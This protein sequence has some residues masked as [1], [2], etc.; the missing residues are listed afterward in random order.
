MPIDNN[1]NGSSTMARKKAFE[2]ESKFWGTEYFPEGLS[3]C[4]F[5]TY[6]Q[7][8]LLEENG[9]TY[10][11]LAE[12]IEAPAFK[13]EESFVDVFTGSKAAETIHEKT[14]KRFLEVSNQKQGVHFSVGA[15]SSSSK[16]VISAQD[17]DV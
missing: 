5:F 9:M 10:K 3:R 1:Q 4:G 14:W 11:A 6:Q 15:D 12:G 16:S 2:A 13:E 8:N 17:D 7:V